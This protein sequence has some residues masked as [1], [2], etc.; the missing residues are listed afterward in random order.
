MNRILHLDARAMDWAHIHALVNH[1][2]VILAVMGALAVVLAVVR[3]QRGI[4]LYATVSLTLAAVTVI[5]TYFTGQ[6]AEH[7][8]NRPWYVAR[9][10]IQTHEDAA[11]ISA[12]LVVLAGLIALFAWRRLV[13]YPREVRMPGSLRAALVVTSLAAALS[14]GYASWLGGRIV[15]DAPALQGPAPAGFV[16]PGAPVPPPSASIPPRAPLADSAPTGTPAGPLPTGPLP[17]G[18]APASSAPVLPRP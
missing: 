6:P 2:P 7:A 11:R 10:A 17:T 12:L 1:F 16:P 4:W 14:I 8:L 18:R 9:D 15:H 5:P 13:R 3:G